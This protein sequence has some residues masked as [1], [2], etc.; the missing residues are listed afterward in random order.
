MERG[1]C[2]ECWCIRGTRL[3]DRSEIKEQTQ[4]FVAPKVYFIYITIIIYRIYN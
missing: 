2:T 4:E 1:E 3:D